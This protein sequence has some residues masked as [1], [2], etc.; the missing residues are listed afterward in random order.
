MSIAFS[1]TKTIQHSFRLTAQHKILF[2]FQTSYR[3][4]QAPRRSFSTTI[5]KMADNA[6]TEQKLL[7]DDV[8]GEMISKT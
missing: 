7:K 8:T 5:A 3:A 6:A 2:N 1:L 4:H